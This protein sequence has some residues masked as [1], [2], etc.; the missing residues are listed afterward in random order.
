[1]ATF[2]QE[3][4]KALAQAIQTSFNQD[5]LTSLLQRE[6]GLSLADLVALPKEWGPLV[7]QV[8]KRSQMEEFEQD[9]ALAV[10]AWRPRNVALAKVL[11]ELTQ[12]P[13]AE[14]T[15]ALSAAALGSQPDKGSALQGLVRAAAKWTDYESFLAALALLGP[16]VCRIEAEG[17]SEGVGTGFLVGDDLVLTNFH[18]RE[19]L[20]NEG[21]AAVC[22]FD[23]RRLAG[24]QA[25]RKGHLVPAADGADAWLAW[26]P[27]AGSD[28]AKGGTP[29]TSKELDYALLRIAEP[30][31]RFPP[32]QDNEG[33]VAHARGHYSLN[34]AV[35]P[36]AAGAD[37]IV[38]Q[39]PGGSP[40]K[41]AIGQT[42]GHPEASS[43]PFRTAHD[44]PTEGGSSGS[45]CLDINLSLRALHHATD[46]EDPSRPDYN[47]AVPIGL[48]VADLI[49][50]GKLS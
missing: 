49:A 33:N 13:G 10:A 37:I 11:R 26:S 30:V 1:M 9:L 18:V 35:V 24:S 2:N 48:I 45:P 12:A 23:Y 46:P 50:K 22:R 34:A 3:Q 14:A 25:L 41:L 38:A 16:R 36:L 47:Q 6:L 5:D 44:A 29:P 20:L 17:D 4:F 42:M 39:H 28:V 21:S 7:T 43:A 19:M 8:V 32:G 40:L 27:Y 31:G 15:L